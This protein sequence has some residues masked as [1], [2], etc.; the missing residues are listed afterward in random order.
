MIVIIIAII[1]EC[2]LSAHTYIKKDIKQTSVVQIYNV[3]EVRAF[4][5]FVFWLNTNK[6]VIFCFLFCY[7]S[8]IHISIE[9]SV[10]DHCCVYAFGDTSGNLMRRTCNHAHTEHCDQCESLE[11]L[12]VAIQKAAHEAKF[13]NQE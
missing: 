8:Q 9:S 3:S 5:L 4:I 12:L 1:R 13:S 10:P 6:F 11:K 2:L 7:L